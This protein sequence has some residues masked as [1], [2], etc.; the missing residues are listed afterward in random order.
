MQDRGEINSDS[1]VAITRGT[2][3]FEIKDTKLVKKAKEILVDNNSS[4]TKYDDLFVDGKLYWPTNNFTEQARMLGQ[5][6]DEDDD[7]TN[8]SYAS[9]GYEIIYIVLVMYTLIFTWTYVK[10][11]VYMAFLTMI[12]PLVALT[13]PIDKARR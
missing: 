4:E 9:I 3:L 8:Y 12:A 11:V 1:D 13:Y 5:L 7:V 10:R 6:T 2:Q